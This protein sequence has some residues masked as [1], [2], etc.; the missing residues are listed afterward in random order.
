MNPVL[1]QL[2]NTGEATAPNG[3]QVRLHSQLP[4]LEGLLLQSWLERYRPVRLLE[5][6]LA[7]GISSLFICDAIQQWPVECYHIIDAF[8]SGQWQQIGVN[9]LHAAGFARLVTMYEELSELCLP[10]FLEQGHR[11]DF[12]FVDGWH[13]FDHVLTE[14]FYISRMLDV[15]GVVVFDDVHLPSIHAVLAH[16]DSY[17]CY[18]RLA[19]PADFPPSMKMKVRKVAGLPPVRI[20]GFVKITPDERDWDWHRDFV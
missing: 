19:L 9:N 18:E 6:G 1:A 7:Y 13:T 17:D 12:A 11:Y 20:A 5:I 3:A 4:E 15:G 14:F 10:R 16:V 2:L 8:Q